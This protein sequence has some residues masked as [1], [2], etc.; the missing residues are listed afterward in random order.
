M[1][2]PLLRVGGNASAI[3]IQSYPLPLQEW[4]FCGSETQFLQLE[5]NTHRWLVRQTLNNSMARK[6]A[7]LRSDWY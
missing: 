2:E 5:L 1:G 3:G 4:W 7:E 6:V